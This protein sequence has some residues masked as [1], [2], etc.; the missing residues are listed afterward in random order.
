VNPSSRILAVA[1][2]AASSQAVAQK[3]VQA[4]PPV[5]A[6]GLATSGLA[7]QMVVVLPLTMVV[8]DPSLPGGS[9]P[10]ARAATIRWADSL[11]ADMLGERGTEVKWIF[12]ADLRRTA[13]RAAGLMPSPDQMGQAVMRSPGLK[14]IPDPLRG[15]VRQVLALS[16][17]A[18][19]AFI[20][21][22]LYLSSAPGDSI[23]VQL[24][25]VLTDGRLGQVLWRTLARG[26]GETAGDAFHAALATIIPPDGA[27]P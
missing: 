23:V 12:P 4:K 18:R 3:P 14:E 6:V 17:G 8:S 7:G 15:Y 24:S 1:F 10:K 25:A 21:A 5:P 19:F 16:G 11:L 13:Q 20:P 2:C 9:G 22:A 27:A 26:Q